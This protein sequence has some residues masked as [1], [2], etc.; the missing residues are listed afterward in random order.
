[1]CVSPYKYL[2]VKDN[3]TG[4]RKVL[5]KLPILISDRYDYDNLPNILFEAKLGLKGLSRY[6][7]F[8][9]FLK[10]QDYTIEDVL[11]VPCGICSE[12]LRRQALD[13]ACRIVLESK[14]SKNCYFVTLTYDDHNVPN[15]PVLDK[16]A[17]SDFNKKL[18]VYLSRL[19]LDSKF[20]FY[21]VGEYGSHTARPHYHVI[22]FNLDLPEDDLV[23]YSTTK[24]GFLQ[25]NSKLLSKVWGKG[26]VVVGNVTTASACYVARYC[27]KKKLLTKREKDELREKGITPEF[28][29]M[30]RRPGI[31]SLAPEATRALMSNMKIQLP[32][33]QSVSVP[34]YFSKKYKAI[35]LPQE[36]ALFNKLR[37]L[38][39]DATFLQKIENVEYAHTD[40][41][42]YNQNQEKIKKTKKRL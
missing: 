9:M 14:Y 3:F 16:H 30:S 17:I 19:G 22:Y 37:Q 21:G 11:S 40:I 15:P 31:G 24:D 13:W 18:K 34:Q 32:N 29:V 8:N 1:M 6:Q 26:F 12:C 20:R 7:T 36:L 33:G 28:S 39:G 10:N 41:F 5:F 2:L 27:D 42:N 38:N 4:K 23:Y 35:L 25:F